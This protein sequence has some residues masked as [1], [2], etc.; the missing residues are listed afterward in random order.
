[1][2]EQRVERLQSELVPAQTR[3]PFGLDIGLFVNENPGVKHLER[4][5][6]DLGHPDLPT[7]PRWGT[8]SY[9]TWFIAKDWRRE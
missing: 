4:W 8:S 5:A 9:L 1:M 7:G 6:T 2:T 3:A